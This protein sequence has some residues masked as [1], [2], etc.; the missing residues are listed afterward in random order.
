M[1]AELM[2]PKL[3]KINMSH[4]AKGGSRAGEPPPISMRRV[5][6]AS[7]WQVV[8]TPACH[9]G[10]RVGSSPVASAKLNLFKLLTVRA[11]SSGT[12]PR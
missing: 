2:G 12:D 3:R 5:A 11:S 1:V 4:D 8:R 9:A 10:G 6:R 7:E